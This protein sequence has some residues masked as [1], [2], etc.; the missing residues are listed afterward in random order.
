MAEWLSVWTIGHIPLPYGFASRQGREKIHRNVCGLAV[1]FRSRF[2]QAYAENAEMC[3]G[4][5]PPHA[6]LVTAAAGDKGAL[7]SKVQ[8]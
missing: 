7:G 3:P 6:A 2:A 5:P 1:A 8:Q 4:L